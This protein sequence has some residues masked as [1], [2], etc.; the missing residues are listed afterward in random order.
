M[1]DA[2][3]DLEDIEETNSLEI[4]L[5]HRGRCSGDPICPICWWK[6]IPERERPTFLF[7]SPPS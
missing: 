1:T 2:T 6:N 4:S 7:I 5:H 3:D